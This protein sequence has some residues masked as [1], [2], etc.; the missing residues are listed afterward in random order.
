MKYLIYVCIPW[1]ELVKFT[2]KEVLV[3]CEMNEVK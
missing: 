1:Q 3:A 2:V